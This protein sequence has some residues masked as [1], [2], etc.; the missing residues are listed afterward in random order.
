MALDIRR[1]LCMFKEG[2]ANGF[3]QLANDRRMKQICCSSHEVLLVKLET[4]F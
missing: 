3:I 4:T 2:A 1:L